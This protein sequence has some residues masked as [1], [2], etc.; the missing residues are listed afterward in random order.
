MAKSYFVLNSDRD[1]EKIYQSVVLW[2]KGKQYEVEGV[3]QNS[4]YLIQARKTGTIRTLLGTNL[5]FKIK[6]YLSDEKFFQ[7]REFIVE[8]SRGKWIQNIAGAGFTSLF[9]GGFTLLTGI[10]GAGVY[11]CCR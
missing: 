3:Y 6:I 9:T 11:A 5:A 4:T 8:T 1:L 7:Q 2:F 10:A